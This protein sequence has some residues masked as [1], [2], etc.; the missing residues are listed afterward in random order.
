[1]LDTI[2]KWTSLLGDVVVII[3]L[4]FAIYQ[5]YHSTSKERDD[6]GFQIYNSLDEKFVEWENLC[7]AHTDLDIFDVPDTTTK[8]LSEKQKKEELI[9]FTILGSLFERA[10]V[11][12]SDGSTKLKQNQWQGWDEYITDFCKRKNFRQAWEITGNT[13]EGEF[14]KYM[15]MK[16]KS[17][18]ITNSSS[19]N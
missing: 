11:L 2:S 15:K 6:R 14:E 3:G 18:E 1:M 9:C 7:L 13:Y 5:Y 8:N 17:T 16:L 12:Y 4:P 19:R 10:F